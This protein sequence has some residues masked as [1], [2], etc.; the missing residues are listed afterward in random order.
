MC[1]EFNNWY[2]HVHWKHW[3]IQLLICKL[4]IFNTGCLITDMTKVEAFYAHLGWNLW[5][6]QTICSKIILVHLL[7]NSENGHYVIIGLS[8]DIFSWQFQL[9]VEF[10]LFKGNYFK[11][12]VSKWHQSIFWKKV[13]KQLKSADFFSQYWCHKK[14]WLIKLPWD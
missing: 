11:D 4:R 9:T 10:T 3:Y 2:N 13:N 8:A 7:S 6:F 14:L 12:T 5:V 1:N